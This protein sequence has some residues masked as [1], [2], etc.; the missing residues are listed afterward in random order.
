MPQVSLERHMKRLIVLCL[1]AGPALATEPPDWYS[2]IPAEQRAALLATRHAGPP[3]ALIGS[4]SP[5]PYRGPASVPHAAPH[6]DPSQI[7]ASNL[8]IQHHNEQ[9]ARVR[10]ILREYRQPDRGLARCWR[11]G[12]RSITAPCR[13]NGCGQRRTDWRSVAIG[14]D[15]T[16]ERWNRGGAMFA[17][18][19][20]RAH[21]VWDR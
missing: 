17:E 15:A 16:L 9:R 4:E 18:F 2:W 8:S 3:A 12:A 19:A 20:L 1:L 14:T 21:R 13:T 7:G 10:R 6:F 11:V 5:L